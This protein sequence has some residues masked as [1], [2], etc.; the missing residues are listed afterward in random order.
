MKNLLN[1]NI[2]LSPV[3]LIKAV[4]VYKDIL[5]QKKEIAR[6]NEG[7]CGVYR[8]TNTVNKKKSILVVVRNWV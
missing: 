6:E 2:S 5:S 3:S 8:W 4:K 1:Q 7:K